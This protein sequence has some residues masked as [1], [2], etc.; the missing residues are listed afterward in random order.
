MRK[1]LPVFAKTIQIK[2]RKA[3]YLYE[4]IQTYTAGMVLQGTEIKAIRLGKVSLQEAYCYFSQ[5]ALW[6]KNMYI[7]PYEQGNIYN[8]IEDRPRKLL[9][10]KKELHTLQKSKEKHLTM[11]PVQLW[12]NERGLAK[13]DIALAK[14]KNI[15]D[16][17]QTLKERDLKRENLRVG[18]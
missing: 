11:V 13:L 17:R 6:I 5:Q 9:L 14:G 10:H 12:I 8:H 15:H 18:L 2:N 7:A 3:R 4:F 1:K 16:K